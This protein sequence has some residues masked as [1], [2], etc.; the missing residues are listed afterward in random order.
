MVYWCMDIQ[1]LSEMELI[2]DYLCIFLNIKLI[3]LFECD[4]MMEIHAK[5]LDF[6]LQHGTLT[7]ATEQRSFLADKKVCFLICIRV[8]KAYAQKALRMPSFLTG[9]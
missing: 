1:E 6:P 7:F 8:T 9:N 5:S 2:Y 4:K 3:R